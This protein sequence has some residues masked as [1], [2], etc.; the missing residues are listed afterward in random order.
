MAEEQ[1]RNA[2]SGHNLDLLFPGADRP[3]GTAQSPACSGASV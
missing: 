3:G 2:D 1:V